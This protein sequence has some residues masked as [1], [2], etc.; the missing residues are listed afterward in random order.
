M[1][2]SER[3]V[4]NLGL[5]IDIFKANEN[6][7]ENFKGPLESL[8]VNFRLP[9]NKVKLHKWQRVGVVIAIL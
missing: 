1:G 5:M 4:I 6:E 8:L 7:L 3:S 2:I 9:I